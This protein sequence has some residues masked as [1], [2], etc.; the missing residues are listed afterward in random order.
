MESLGSSD[1]FLSNEGWK[2]KYFL[3]REVNFF[4]DH[5]KLEFSLFLWTD[6][7]SPVVPSDVVLPN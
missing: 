6:K 3:N 4:L 7:V 2:E 5:L 1:L